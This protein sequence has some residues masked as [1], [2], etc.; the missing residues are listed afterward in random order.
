M[1]Q[2]FLLVEML[3]HTAHWYAITKDAIERRQLAEVKAALFSQLN[4]LVNHNIDL[5]TC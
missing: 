2:L 4:V 5:N 1:S 3:I